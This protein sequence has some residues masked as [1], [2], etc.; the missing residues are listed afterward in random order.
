MPHTI[1]GRW[2][3]VRGMVIHAVYSVQSVAGSSYCLSLPKYFVV[4]CV[5]SVTNDAVYD[6]WQ[7]FAN[8]CFLQLIVVFHLSFLF[9]LE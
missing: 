3:R 6:Q 4:G 8:C 7:L 9:Q 1:R 5:Q 2:R